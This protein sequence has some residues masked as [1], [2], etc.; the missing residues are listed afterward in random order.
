MVSEA[1]RFVHFNTPSVADHK[2]AT[3]EIHTALYNVFTFIPKGVLIE[4]FSRLANAYFAVVVFFQINPSTTNSDGISYTL[5]ILT[6]VIFF[7]SYL[8]LKQDLA[9]H[10]ADRAANSA[11][12]LRYVDGAFVPA[13]W[14]DVKV[15]DFLKVSNREGL[16][17]DM[18]LV[19]THEPDPNH[20]SGACYIE[21]K[22]LDG[23]TNLKGRSVPGPLTLAC[24]GTLA[25]QT[26]ACQA[27]AGHVE[28]EQPNA[29]T[30]KFV[31]TLTLRPSVLTQAA[32]TVPLNINNMLLRGSVVRNTEYVIGLVINTG[33][34]TKV[35]QGARKPPLKRSFIDRAINVMMVSILVT[36][37]TACFIGAAAELGVSEA[38]HIRDAWYL[39]SDDGTHEATTFAIVYLRYFVLLANFVSV[40]LYFSVDLNKHVTA[41]LIALNTRMHHADS[42]TTCKVRTAA[43]IDELGCISHVFSDKTGTLTQNVMQFRKCSV[44][45]VAYGR[46]TTEIGRARL[47]RTGMLPNAD[48]STT[49]ASGGVSGVSRG[50]SSSDSRR[51]L[52]VSECSAAAAS[53][54]P[55]PFGALPDEQVSFDGPELYAGLRGEQG[56]EQQVKLR[57]FVTLLALCHT[58]V[59]EEIDG[60][61]RL[62]ASSPDEAALVA[63]AKYLGIEF[64]EKQHGIVTLRDS[65]GDGTEAGKPQGRSE[66][67]LEGEMRT[68]EMLEVLEFTSARKRM[69]V[70]VREA[71]PSGRIKLL[72]KGADNI[73]LP[74]LA[75]ES[76][77]MRSKTEGH[78]E[79]HAN[80]GLRT[81]VVAE[82]VLDPIMYAEWSSAYTAALTDISEIEKKEKEQPN[83]IDGLMDQMESGL[84]LLGSTAIEDKLQDGVPKAVADLNRAGIAVWVLTGDKEETAI[85]IAYACELFDTRTKVHVFNTSVAPDPQALHEAFLART[86]EAQSDAAR[87]GGEGGGGG[88]KHGIVI[89]GELISMVFADRQLQHDLLRLSSLCASLVACRCAPS[90]KAQLV[91]LVKTNVVGA[92]TLAI[93]DGANDV[94]MIQAAHVGIGIS[95]QEG[96]QAANSA[97]FSFGQFRFLLELLLVHGRNCYR[98]MSTQVCYIFYKNFLLTMVVF[99]YLTYNSVS[100]QKFYLEGAYAAFN[101][102]WTGLPIIVFALLDCDVD[103]E[104]ARATP[105]LY[106]LGV[107][108]VYFNWYV[109]GRWALMGLIESVLIFFPICAAL[110]ELTPSGESPGVWQI[111]DFAYVY[112]LLIVSGKLALES[113]QVTI[114]QQGLLLF[115]FV[116][117]WPIAGIASQDWVTSSSYLASMA[118]GYLGVY[119]QTQQTPTYW[120]LMLL[121]PVA[122]LL[123][124]YGYQAF[125]R[126]FA[127]EFRDLVLEASHHNLGKRLAALQQYRIPTSQ[128]TL[129]LHKNAPREIEPVSALRRCAD[130]LSAAILGHT[131]QS[132]ER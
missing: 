107:R 97:D 119:S 72:T 36:Q 125:W 52:S 47:E 2:F 82:K 98:R 9:R 8:K 26:A 46:G 58:V 104:V 56:D 34:D 110:D 74:L 10:K 1:T 132:G 117:W 88:S 127:P 19:A 114:W 4:E 43:L 124:Q 68:Y 17:A 96:M 129:P 77:A 99:W 24:G 131:D 130:S 3:N 121:L 37:V 54:R 20:P 53:S 18:L 91:L 76:E 16:P 71:G 67:L 112:I 48:E 111:G 83:K 94:A 31:G 75:P 40:S 115:S 92:T 84:T 93:G 49:A 100:G 87:G 101:L 7:A 86:A 65:M 35:M 5:P 50:G 13:V 42:Y 102:I 79:D 15:G 21:T 11:K 78:L 38:E 64:V 95:G 109:V 80:D 63:A 30:R 128:R 32:E 27:L 45:G 23:E 116:I 61:K 12:T 22:S 122:L 123:P 14:T 33:V 69:S 6:V 103:H 113:W 120:A 106:H 105:Q 126:L 108:R 73:M 89:D 85:N 41:R 55:G 44:N 29:A 62:S 90:Q 81:L 118:E 66:H 28:C 39:K 57:D 51:E 60:A 25:S 70:V 59:V